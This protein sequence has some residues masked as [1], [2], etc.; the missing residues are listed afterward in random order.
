MP[1]PANSGNSYFNYQPNPQNANY[2]YPYN[3]QG[4]PVQYHTSPSNSSIHDQSP[5]KS[6]QSQTPSSSSPNRIPKPNQN[7]SLTKLPGLTNLTKPLV[8]TNGTTNYTPPPP[9]PH[10]PTPTKTAFQPDSALQKMASLRHKLQ[11]KVKKYLDGLEAATPGENER[12]Y[13]IHKHLVANEHLI[14]GVLTQCNHVLVS[15]FFFG[16]VDEFRE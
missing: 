8:S 13:A 16:R 12:L 11:I 6:S 5:Q 15:C 9:K 2:N 4:T 10:L 14:N 1:L 3:Q 7:E